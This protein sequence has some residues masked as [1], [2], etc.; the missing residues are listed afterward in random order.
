MKTSE[1]KAIIAI[2]LTTLLEVDEPAPETMLYLGI[3]SGIGGDRFDINNFFEVKQIL[4]DAGL[5]SVS[6]HLVE[7]TD[8]GRRIASSMA[9]ALDAL[10]TK[11][12]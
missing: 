3:Q 8:R 11:E 4:V 7:L 2:V 5:V 9:S 1:M 12:G 10:K 6:Y